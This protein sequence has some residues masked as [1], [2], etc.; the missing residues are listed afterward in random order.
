MKVV[1]FD[2]GHDIVDSGVDVDEGLG[3]DAGEVLLSE[4]KLA[5]MSAQVCLPR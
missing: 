3:V 2:A 5:I 4:N 1:P